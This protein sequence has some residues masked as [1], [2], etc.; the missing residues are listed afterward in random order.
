MLGSQ[1]LVHIQP[2]SMELPHPK[3]VITRKPLDLRKRRPQVSGQ[4]DNHGVA[5]LCFFL[6]TDDDGTNLPL[7]QHEFAVDG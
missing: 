7:Q 5:P 1:P 2:G 6:L 3:Y 4:L